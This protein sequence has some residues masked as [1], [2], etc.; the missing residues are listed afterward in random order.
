MRICIFG[1]SFNPVHVGH[2]A[3][4]RAVISAS[5]AD[6][7]WL[8]VSPQ[9]PL[10]PADTLW[11]EDLRLQLARKAVADC[12]GIE[13]SDFEFGLP[14]PSYTY[15]TLC[16]LR[17]AYP[18]HQ[19][20]LLIGADN[21]EIFDRW[22][23]AAE[24][25]QEFGVIIYPRPGYNLP[26]LQNPTRENSNKSPIQESLPPEHVTI[27]DAPTYDVSSTKIREAL[28]RGEDVSKMVPNG[29]AETLSALYIEK[30]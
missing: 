12:E 20:C 25:L 27:L 10:K 14:R 6:Q 17:K 28:V 29:I 30:S 1:G 7:V 5:L 21:W 18:E 13:A 19:F 9:N 8:M 15:A 2:I 4:A 11:N 22:R 24:I 16:A 23:N 26:N 3:L